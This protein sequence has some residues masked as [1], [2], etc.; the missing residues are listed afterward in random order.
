M[1]TIL[2]LLTSYK[3]VTDETMAFI[4]GCIEAKN[5]KHKLKA[6]QYSQ[7]ELTEDRGC[8]YLKLE[9][10]HEEAFH[11]RSIMLISHLA[12]ADDPE[13]KSC[14]AYAVDSAKEYD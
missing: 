3:L 1:T 2:L 8:R 13:D 10:A 5:N 7:M 12:K 6:L 4:D 9:M 14:L 11:S